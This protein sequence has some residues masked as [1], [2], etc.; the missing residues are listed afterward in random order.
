MFWVKWDHQN[1][2]RR[3]PV[4]ESDDS[5]MT[6]RC[7]ETKLR[8]IVP[9]FTGKLAWKDDDGNLVPLLSAIDL[10]V[11]LCQPHNKKLLRI[12][13]IDDIAKTECSKRKL[14]DEIEYENLARDSESRGVNVIWDHHGQCRMFE[15]TAN[16][17]YNDLMTLLKRHVPDFEEMLC[18]KDEEDD[19]V[20]I[21]SDA[22]L[23]EAIRC[24]C[25]KPYVSFVS[26]ELEGLLI[27]LFNYVPFDDFILMATVCSYIIAGQDTENLSAV[28]AQCCKYGKEEDSD[29][30]ECANCD[31]RFNGIRYECAV[32]EDTCFCSNCEKNGVHDKHPLVRLSDLTVTVYERLFSTFRSHVKDYSDFYPYFNA[33]KRQIIWFHS[34]SRYHFVFDVAQG[35]LEL[36]SYM[37][38]QVPGFDSTVEWQDQCG[39]WHEIFDDNG[40]KAAFNNRCNFHVLQ[41]Y[42]A[43]SEAIPSFALEKS[44]S[45]HQPSNSLPY[46][47]EFKISQVKASLKS[48]KSTRILR[49]VL[50]D[51][52]NSPVIDPDFDKRNQ[53]LAEALFQKICLSPITD[54]GSVTVV[55]NSLVTEVKTEPAEDVICQVQTETVQDTDQDDDVSLNDFDCLSDMAKNVADV[56]SQSDGSADDWFV[57]KEKV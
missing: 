20:E 47:T 3:F 7:F 52:A 18:W 13:T 22:E 1:R 38:T 50:K 34:G 31:R 56:E 44:D 35:F 9:D 21:S 37:K 6:Y 28:Q 10:H 27:F 30:Y 5:Y 29:Y 53:L 57:V 51:Q 36:I 33:L 46:T 55:D 26:F 14:I 15:I 23:A 16:I 11:A 25:S 17:S 45:N 43:L 2:F 12:F 41:L 48:E 19:L 8:Q 49:K 40:L 54:D 39:K 42:T 32:C 4:T 24:Q